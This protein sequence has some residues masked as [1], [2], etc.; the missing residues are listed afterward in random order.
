MADNKIKEFFQLGEVGNYFIRVFKKTDPN[1]KSNLNLRMMHGINRISI[2][3]FLA[4]LIFWI[5][6]RFM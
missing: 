5:V 1:Q 3:I 6:K 4:A 2:L